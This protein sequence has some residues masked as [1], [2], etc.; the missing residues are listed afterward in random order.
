M[1][2]SNSEAT[3]AV[4]LDLE[5]LALGAHEAN[6]PAFD[7]RKVIERLLLK[8]WPRAASTH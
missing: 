1:S 4:F 8:R 2:A 3:L 6:F 7:I 5:N